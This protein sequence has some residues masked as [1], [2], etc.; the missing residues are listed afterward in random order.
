M[1]SEECSF[2]LE[3]SIYLD[4][5]SEHRREW[6]GIG[7][8]EKLFFFVQT[9]LVPVYFLSQCFDA[10]GRH[11]KPT[12]EAKKRHKDLLKRLNPKERTMATLQ[13]KKPAASPSKAK[14]SYQKKKHQQPEVEEPSTSTTISMEDYDD[15]DGTMT[16][17]ADYMSTHSR[18]GGGYHHDDDDDHV[19]LAVVPGQFHRRNSSTKQIIVNDQ[20]AAGAVGPGGLSK[21]ANPW[22]EKSFTVRKNS[23]RNSSLLQLAQEMEAELNELDISRQ[24]LE[25][26]DEDSRN[27]M[28]KMRAQKGLRGLFKK[29]KAMVGGKKKKKKKSV[30][31]QESEDFH[32]KE[33][34][35]ERTSVNWRDRGLL[36]SRKDWKGENCFFLC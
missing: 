12:Q 5:S 34:E 23:K 36:A 14:R 16:T 1:T 19:I 11:L 4:V 2:S 35:E 6:G 7:T 33:R 10:H 28:N 18:T 25:E 30:E 29:A 27:L 32:L 31:G 3:R 26:A 24:E 17:D 8:I 15:H 9:S 22:Q 13:H 20:P 21:N